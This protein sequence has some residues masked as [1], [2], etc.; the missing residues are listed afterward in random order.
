MKN[1]TPI[2]LNQRQLLFAQEY[3]VSGNALQSAIKAGYASRS[4]NVTGSR[5]LANVHVSAYIAQKQ[6]ASIAKNDNLQE[7]ILAELSHMAFSNL[8]DFTTLD[9]D[10]RRS[11]DFSRASRE[12]LAALTKIKTKTRHIYTPKGD[13]IG[14]EHSDE[15]S[16][17][18]KY[19][20]LKLLGQT[21]GMFKQ[22][23]Q[24]IVVDVA[25]R[26]L[27]GRARVMAL[28]QKRSDDA[29]DE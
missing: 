8:E 6:N 4:A 23:E 10:G 25:D 13:H 7:R 20:G 9:A 19:M 24:R 17:A 15:F 22:E 26:I 12:Q 2:D 5:L 29:S 3:L 28:T 1:V 14:T 21:V 16:L 18:D 27:E 11:V